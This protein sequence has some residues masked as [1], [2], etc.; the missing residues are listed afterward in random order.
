MAL[1]SVNLDDIIA[2]RE[3]RK[4][5]EPDPVQ[6]AVLTELAG[7]DGISLQY[8]RGVGG[9]RNRDLFVLREVVKTKLTIEIPPIDDVIASVL[10]VKPAMVS[11]FAEHADANTPVAGIDF[12]TAQ[13]DFGEPTSRLKGMGIT[14]CFL[15]DP[16]P[17]SVKGAAKAGADAVM[18]NCAGFTLARTIEEAQA[19]LDRIDSAAQ[20]ASKAG[21]FIYAA[22]NISY[23]NVLPLH[24]LGLIDEFFV[25]QAITSRAILSGMDTAVRDLMNLIG[26]SQSKS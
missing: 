1:L 15:I 10:E 7:A 17:S 18:L 4:L 25:G 23:K 24:E 20:A 19:E 14:V 26:N 22:R 5:R 3:R 2:L 13:I 8:R 12:D 11:F 16:E 21:L 9:V 6:A